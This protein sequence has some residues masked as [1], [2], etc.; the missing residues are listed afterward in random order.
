MPEPVISLQPAVRC[1]RDASSPLSRLTERGLPSLRRHLLSLRLSAASLRPWVRRTLDVVT[2]G[3]GLLALAPAFLLAAL[4][5]RL[6]SRG[7]IFFGQ[8]RVGQNGRRFTMWKLR[9]MVLNADALKDQLQK[10][11]AASG[12]VRFKMVADPRITRVGRVLRKLSLDE[13]PQLFNVFIG[14]MT[15]IGPRPP[16]YR[17]V[18]LYH[19]RALRRLEVKPGLT[20]L[21]QVRGRSNLSFEQ[22]VELDIE[23]I[24]RTTASDEL[25][26]LL[27]TVPAVL[28]GRGAY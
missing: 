6:T 1:D 11:H 25:Q 9:T 12:G 10:Q 13:L 16:V 26:I 27:A 17:E 23:Y 2:C 22:Q 14:D 4:A 28:T 18:A 15:L 21:W 8:E 20:C 24:D 3:L 7:P 5:I 19:S